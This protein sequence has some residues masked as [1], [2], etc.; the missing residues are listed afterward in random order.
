LTQYYRITA[1]G[2]LQAIFLSRSLAR[3]QAPIHCRACGDV[4]STIGGPDSKAICPVCAPMFS[5]A[6]DLARRCVFVG[7]KRTSMRLEEMFW[8]V[9]TKAASR[10]GISRRTLMTA[11]DEANPLSKNLTSTVRL[12]CMT[13]VLD[14]LTLAKKALAAK[15]VFPEERYV[16]NKEMDV[17][18]KAGAEGE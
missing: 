5:I 1:P 13:E 4:I 9:F 3:P 6:Q 7:D 2:R 11:L 14:M 16:P 8:S 10:R 17:D 18:Q 15:A 12:F